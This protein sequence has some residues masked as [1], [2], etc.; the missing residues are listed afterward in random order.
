MIPVEWG[1]SMRYQLN[2]ER[3]TELSVHAVIDSVTGRLGLC[4]ASLLVVVGI[5]AL[6]FFKSDAANLLVRLINAR[7]RESISL[8]GILVCVMLC[9]SAIGLLALT[10][11]RCNVLI[12]T[13]LDQE[14]VI[15]DKWLQY[16]FRP[17]GFLDARTR[18]MVLVSADGVELCRDENTG[19]ITIYGKVWT[20]LCRNVDTEWPCSLKSM[21]RLECYQLPDCFSPDPLRDSH[22]F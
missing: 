5:A 10:W 17:M 20:K 16:S 3:L 7:D 13:R 8:L 22:L 21:D 19:I 14:L 6:F 12:G 18:V 1:V 4:G 11:N 2:N 15:D 9:A